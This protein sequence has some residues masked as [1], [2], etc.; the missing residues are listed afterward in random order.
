V[1]PA[2]RRPRPPVRGRVGARTGGAARALWLAALGLLATVVLAACQGGASVAAPDAWTEAE[3]AGV[4]DLSELGSDLAA[5]ADGDHLTLDGRALPP[6]LLERI[7]H[8]SMGRSLNLLRLSDDALAAMTPDVAAFLVR[9]AP[10]E[11]RDRLAGYGL[12]VPDV[13]AAWGASGALD[14]VGLR[15]VAARLDA[16]AGLQVA[17]VG[18]GTRLLADLGVAR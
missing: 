1:R 9:A 17:G 18:A 2:A 6:A 4:F 14:L 16:E 8:L 12:A 10:G 13:R 15:A 11:L 5:A 7:P 3:L